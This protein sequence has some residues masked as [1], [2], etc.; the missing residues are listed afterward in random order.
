MAPIAQAS[1][2]S[3]FKPV[4]RITHASAH[5]EQ[6]QLASWAG[7]L[8]QGFQVIP[9]LGG[10]ATSKGRAL[11]RVVALVV[12]VDRVPAKGTADLVAVVEHHVLL[13][14]AGIVVVFVDR[15]LHPRPDVEV[16]GVAHMPPRP[17][18]SRR[19][20][21]RSGHSR[22]YDPCSRTGSGRCCRPSAWAASPSHPSGWAAWW[23]RCAPSRS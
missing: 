7:M 19:W 2:A 23:C 3:G 21:S 1:S 6:L 12:E 20:S 8:V 17:R 9:S 10:A 22:S 4:A 5:A 13:V 16:L 18:S 15:G 11:G 14:G